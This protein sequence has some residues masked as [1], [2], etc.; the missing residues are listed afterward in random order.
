LGAQSGTSRIEPSSLPTHVDD[1]QTDDIFDVFANGRRRAVFHYLKQRDRNA[2]IDLSN[3]STRVASWEQDVD[4]SALDYDERKSVHT[5]L[6][7]FHLPKMDRAGLVEFEKQSSTVTLTE[8]GADIDIY[9]ETVPE[10]DI[11]W[12]SYFVT[13]TGAGTGLA[14][15][16]A[17]GDLVPIGGDGVAVL[18]A[19][20]LLVSSLVF[21]HQTRNEMRVGTSGNP[22]SSE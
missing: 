5:S 16:T 14:G 11:P 8:T 1:E 18:I 6:Y 20:T 10:D 7:Q 4:P 21:Y 22:P 17:V 15:V 19:V 3:L 9:L 2:E 12:A 13:V